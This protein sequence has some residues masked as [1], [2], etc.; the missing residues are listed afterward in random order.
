MGTRSGSYD[1][2][3]DQAE[4]AE[5]LG[6]DTVVLG[7]RHFRHADLLYPSPFI[8][9]AAL[10]ART[11]RIRIGMAARILSLDHPIHIAEDAATLDVLSEGRLDFGVTRASLDQESHSV[12]QSPHNESRRRFKEA[13]EVIVKAWSEEEFTFEGQYHRIPRVS[14]YP[15]PR[16][17]PHPPISVV[18]VSPETLVFAA[19]QGYSA[20]L[21]A[22]G[23]VT[24]LR[25]AVQSY[26]KASKE[27]GLSGTNVEVKI[28]RFIY[29]SSTD[30]KARSEIEGAFMDFI[31]N[32]APDLK[33]ALLTRYGSEANLSFDRCLN[34]FCLFGS[35]DSVIMRI[36]ELADKVDFNYLLCSLNFITLDHSLCVKSMELFAKEVMPVFKSKEQRCEDLK[37]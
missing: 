33:G 10:A 12:F 36:Q 15:K 34:D 13:L 29:L 6:F 4:R 16:Q 35:P 19:E 27:A 21:G 25:K 26:W 31:E 23:S 37:L 9:A 8:V 32:R 14:V 5:Q 17:K 18:A 20:I 7:E 1:D 24:D 30:E 28:N 2:I 3:F 11:T 22:I